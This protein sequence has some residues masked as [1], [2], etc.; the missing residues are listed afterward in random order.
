MELVS[1]RARVALLLV[2][3]AQVLLGYSNPQ[4]G[5]WGSVQ[6]RIRPPHIKRH[7]PGKWPDPGAS[8]FLQSRRSSG[9]EIF[10]QGLVVT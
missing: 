7:K 2:I 10:L 6:E 4:D 1:L 9:W 3:G 8:R 5:G